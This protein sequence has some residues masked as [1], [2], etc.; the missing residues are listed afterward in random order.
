MYNRDKTTYIVGKISGKWYCPNISRS[1]ALGWWCYG[2]RHSGHWHKCLLYWEDRCYPKAKGPHFS[3]GEDG[4]E[5]KK[6]HWIAIIEFLFSCQLNIVL[7]TNSDHK[8]RMGGGGWGWVSRMA[9][10]WPC[11]IGRWMQPLSIPVSRYTVI[12]YHWVYVELLKLTFIGA[13]QWQNRLIFTF[14]MA[15]IWEDDIRNVSW[16]NCEKGACKDGWGRWFI[17]EINPRWSVH[18]VHT[19]VN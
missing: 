19:Q 4:T 15:D 9:Y 14:L 18:S 7:V 10:L 16:W 5:T 11:S 8:H 3:F 17:W 12:S 13:E 2:D 1:K 6:V